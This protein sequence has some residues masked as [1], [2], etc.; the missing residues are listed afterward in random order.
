[1]SYEDI[2]S[3]LSTQLNAIPNVT[4]TKND[5][6]KIQKGSALVAILSYGGFE[7]FRFAHNG[8]HHIRWRIRIELLA[9]YTTDADVR[10]KLRDFRMAVINRINKYPRLGLEDQVYD[11]MVTVGEPV[12]EQ[13]Q[14]GSFQYL[15]EAVLCVAE[16]ELDVTYEE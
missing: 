2:E 12:E 11:A 8:V 15:R 9:K 1:M 16:E 7:Q 3:A 4:V 14:V 10:N 6:T 13:V 5:G